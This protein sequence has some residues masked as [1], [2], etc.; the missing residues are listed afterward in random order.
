MVLDALVVLDGAECGVLRTERH[1]GKPEGLHRR[2]GVVRRN[3]DLEVVLPNLLGAQQ[4]RAQLPR[5]QR[6]WPEEPLG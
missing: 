3:V 6:W 4:P 2:D 1:Q 5:A